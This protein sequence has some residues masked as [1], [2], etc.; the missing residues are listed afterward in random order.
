MLKQLKHTEL[1][2]MIVVVIEGCVHEDV[3]EEHE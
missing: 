2:M 1:T 3:H